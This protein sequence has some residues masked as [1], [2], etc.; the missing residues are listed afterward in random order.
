MKQIPIEKYLK[1]EIVSA[2]L[3]CGKK[4]S[5]KQDFPTAVDASSALLAL[6]T[7]DLHHCND[8]ETGV[9]VPV[10]VKLHPVKEESVHADKK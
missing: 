6:S 4:V 3:S 2:C 7:K 1:G 5:R 9:L 10:G 8:H